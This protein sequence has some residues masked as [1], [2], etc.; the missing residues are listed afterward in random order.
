M[1]K[2]ILTADNLAARGMQHNPMCPLCNN[3]T[4]YTE[5]LLIDCPFNKEVLKLLWAWYQY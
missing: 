3:H 2:R 1:H 5:N 4:E